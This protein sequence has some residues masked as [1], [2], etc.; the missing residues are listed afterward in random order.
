MRMRRV[1]GETKSMENGSVGIGGVFV[2]RGIHSASTGLMTASML[3]KACRVKYCGPLVGDFALARGRIKIGQL[4]GQII[5]VGEIVE[6]AADIHRIIQ[7]PR[8]V[9]GSQSRSGFTDPGNCAKADQHTTAFRLFF[10]NGMI[11]VEC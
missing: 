10:M 8:R 2:R 6:I 7:Q 1:R 5:K 11:S 3:S 9:G 4:V